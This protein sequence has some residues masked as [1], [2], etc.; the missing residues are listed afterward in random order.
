MTNLR[1]PCQR[2]LCQRLL[3]HNTCHHTATTL[4]RHCDNTANSVPP[5]CYH[6]AITLPTRPPLPTIPAPHPTKAQKSILALVPQPM[7]LCQL[8]FC[9]WQ[10]CSWQSFPPVHTSL[11]NLLKMSILKSCI[12]QKFYKTHTSLSVDISSSPWQVSR[13]VQ[14]GCSFSASTAGQLP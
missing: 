1:L 10:V 9:L 4:R 14:I 5:H 12:F 3:C 2:V 7:C 13:I 8:Y 11:H 6:C